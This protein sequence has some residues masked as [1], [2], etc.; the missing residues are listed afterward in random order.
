M[1]VMKDLEVKG[2]V[3]TQS[4][5]RYDKARSLFYGGV[6]KHPAAIVRV[7]NAQ[8]VARVVEH[9]APRAVALNPAA[10]VSAEQHG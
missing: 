3:I 1:K 7:A 8:D 5:P 9:G 2:D 10:E 6:D 4:D